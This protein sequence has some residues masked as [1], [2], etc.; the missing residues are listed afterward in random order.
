MHAVRSLPTPRRRP[1]G[2]LLVA[3]VLVL[4]LAV[5]PA[6]VRLFADYLWFEEIGFTRVLTT[7]LGARAA[8]FAAVALAAF[9]FLY[10][11]PGWRSAGGRRGRS[12]SWGRRSGRRST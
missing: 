6:L 2:R 12:W 4:V 1:R 10:L 7:E 11:T 5:F 9:A 8:V 3:L